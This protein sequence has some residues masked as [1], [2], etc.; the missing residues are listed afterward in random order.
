MKKRLFITCIV[1]V[2]FSKD[3]IAAG[4]ERKRDEKEKFFL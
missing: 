3:A 4:R 2:L 1:V